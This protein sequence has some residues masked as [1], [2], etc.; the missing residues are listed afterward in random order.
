MQNRPVGH[1]AE[2]VGVAAAISIAVAGRCEPEELALPVWT[3]AAPSR[4]DP[5][6]VANTATVTPEASHFGFTSAPEPSRIVSSLLI[7]R[8]CI[9]GVLVAV[10]AS[11]GG[12]HY[13]RP[14]VGRNGP[15]TGVDNHPGPV[16]HAY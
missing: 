12:G 9:G 16:G 15:R 7:F 10:R 11:P 3:E 6:T 5:V 2:A 1:V 13:A 14:W 4:R 8:M